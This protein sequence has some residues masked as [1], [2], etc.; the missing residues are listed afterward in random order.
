MTN[1]FLLTFRT[2]A[3]NMPISL[4]GGKWLLLHITCNSLAF[5]QSVYLTVGALYLFVPIMGRVGAGNNSEVMLGLLVTLLYVLLVSYVV[6]LILLV[7]GVER[8]F[9]LFLGLFLLSIAVLILTPL[10]F[11]YSAEPGSLAP[12]RF[13]I[14]VS[15]FFI[16]T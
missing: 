6:P 5:V 4:L 9:S 10:G 8:V 13:M 16:S 11:P 15:T 12:Q 1:P 14:A 2:N 3:C 7:R